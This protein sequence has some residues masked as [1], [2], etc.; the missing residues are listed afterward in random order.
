MIFGGEG[1][2]SSNLIIRVKG[3]AEL[4]FVMREHTHTP[5]G[6]LPDLISPLPSHYPCDASLAAFSQP[7]AGVCEQSLPRWRT[8][9]E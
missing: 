3:G 4:A 8:T 9:R 2:G 6:V 5:L 7:A 1:R